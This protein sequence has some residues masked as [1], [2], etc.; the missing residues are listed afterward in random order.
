MSPPASWSWIQRLRLRSQTSWASWHLRRATKAERRLE[1]RLALLQQSVDST[2][3]ALKEQELLR[4]MAE[5]R[6]AEMQASQLHHEQG[7]LLPAPPSPEPE[8]QPTPALL[9]LESYLRSR[10]QESTQP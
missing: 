9:A 6:L 2:H 3:L 7:I 1:R 10:A 8:S 4:E 5:H